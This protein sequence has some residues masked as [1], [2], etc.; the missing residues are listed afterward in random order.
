MYKVEVGEKDLNPRSC[1]NCIFYSTSRRRC[2][3]LGVNIENPDDPPC[4]KPISKTEEKAPAIPKAEVIEEK[5][6]VA[7]MPQPKPEVPEEKAAKI[8]PITVEKPPKVE[9]PPPPRV[10]KVVPAISEE[11]REELIKLLKDIEDRK[12]TIK[13][14]ADQ[15]QLLDDLRDRVSP[16]IYEKIRSDYVKKRDEMILKLKELEEKAVSLGAIRC[17]RCG[18]LTLPDTKFCPKC[19]SPLS[20]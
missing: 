13:E 20:A 17:K 14:F 9:M 12:R 8:Q 19:G 6:A 5:V 2:L 3:K 1:L 16:E 15:I 4:L 7:P 18:T 11:A 10:E